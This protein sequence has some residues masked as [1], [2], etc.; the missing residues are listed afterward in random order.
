MYFLCW[1][2]A[3][4][5]MPHPPFSCKDCTKFKHDK[6]MLSKKQKIPLFIYLFLTRK[7][8]PHGIRCLFFSSFYGNDLFLLP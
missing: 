2:S 4:L 6:E 7:M 5:K 8:I 3:F 1:V